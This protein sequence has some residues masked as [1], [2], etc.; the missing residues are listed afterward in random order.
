MLSPSV[1]S[2]SNFTATEIANIKQIARDEKRMIQRMNKKEA[3]QFL[4][5]VVGIPN[6]YR[7]RAIS[8]KKIR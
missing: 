4:Y 6:V 3:Q 5:T 7:K 8:S 1:T 2:Y